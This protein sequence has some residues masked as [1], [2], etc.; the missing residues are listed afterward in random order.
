MAFYLGLD[1]HVHRVAQRSEQTCEWLDHLSPQV[2]RPCIHRWSRVLFLTWAALPCTELIQCS[3]LV[4]PSKR[5]RRQSCTSYITG[6]DSCADQSQF[7]VA[8]GL[9]LFP[10]TFDWA[11]IAYIGS[12]LVTPF[13]AAMN[14]VAGLVLVMW[15]AAPIMCKLSTTK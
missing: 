3:H 7:G 1:C 14:I 11:Q 13:W 6:N 2:L 15:L 5:C 4:R 9:G 8:S 10:V 12:P